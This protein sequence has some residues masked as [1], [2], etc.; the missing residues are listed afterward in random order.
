[1]PVSPVLQRP[2]PSPAP[3]ATILPGHDPLQRTGARPAVPGGDLRIDM[4][5][6]AANRDGHQ[7]EL[8]PKEFDLLA[9]LAA[10]PGRTFSRAQLLEEV[11][12]S[13]S[14][15]QGP[16]TVTE[17][18]HRLRTKMRRDVDGPELVLT[19][20]G[21]GYRFEPGDE[22]FDG[23]GGG[24]RSRHN[25][26]LLL[27]DGT[28]RFASSAAREL[29]APADA[30]DILGRDFSDYLAPSSIDAAAARLASAEAGHWP[31]PELVWLLRAGGS[32]VPVEMASMPV[33]W[34][35]QDATQIMLW[36]ASS[37]VAPSVDVPTAHHATRDHRA[38]GLR[39]RHPHR[40]AAPSPSSV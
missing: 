14:D 12:S 11:W 9:F 7:L 40:H 18:V 15:W 25:A 24:A 38:T 23:A 2:A 29:M 6:R 32:E 17:H 22:A 13:S 3:T 26:V 28:I 39:G 5:A 31:R 37:Q 19:V 1:M 35:G 27:V 10:R 34:A 4:E 36:P 20:K 30:S 8:T 21:A 33:Q 16:A